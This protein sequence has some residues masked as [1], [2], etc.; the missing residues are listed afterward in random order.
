MNVLFFGAFGITLFKPP[1]LIYRFAILQDKTIPGSVNE[2]RIARYCKKVTIV[3]VIF[4]FFNGTITAFTIFSGSDVLWAVYNGGVSYILMGILFVWEYIIRRMVQKKMP[5]FVALSEIKKESRKPEDVICYEGVWSENRHRTWGD[6][7]EGTA[8]LRRRIETVKGDRWLLYCDDGWHFILA[9]TAL[10]QCKKEVLLAPTTS[11]GFIAGVK[12]DGP[13][14]TDQEFP[15]LDNCHNVPALLDEKADAAAQATE[16]PAINGEESFVLFYTSGST[17]EPKMVRQRLKEFEIDNRHLM[18]SWEWSDALASRKLCTTVTHQHIYGFIV[19]MLLP[20][21]AG[22]PFRTKMISSPSELEKFSDTGYALI[23]VP[24]FL[25]RAVEMEIPLKLSMKSPWILSSGGLLTDDVAQK[26]SEVFGFWPVEMYA[27][28]ETSGIG[29]RQSSKGIEWTPFGNVELSVNEY[30][31]LVVRSP[32]VIDE[33]GQPMGTAETSDLAKLLPDGRFILMGRLDSLVKIEE[34]RVSLPDM[35]N[36]ISQSGLVSDVAVIPM[37]DRRQ[38]LA[39]A[40]V[41]NAA[42]K[43]K[44]AGLEKIE[45]NKFWREYVLQFFDNI[46]VPK[47]WRYVES[48]PADSQ[49]KKK[50]EDIEKLFTDEQNDG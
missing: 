22:I 47:K 6:F 19:S 32:N 4:I 8:A 39:A 43:E 17:G 3:W 35:E 1:S 11:P 46:L 21:N 29:W 10:F 31:C 30:N 18:T 36:R 44:F 7:L 9:L 38:Y 14:L 28:T 42:G 40:L 48:L 27:S 13:F 34:K 37:E 41:F 20:F 50:R 45:I 12:R 5:N 23:T 33:N 2:N 15:G 25:K 24:A 16:C 26:T 49:G